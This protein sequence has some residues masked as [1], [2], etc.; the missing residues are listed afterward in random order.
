MPRRLHIHDL[1]PGLLT[2]NATQAHHARQVLRLV[3]GD[4]VELFDDAGRVARAEIVGGE[5]HEL[6]LR[7]DVVQDAPEFGF[8]WTVAAAVPKGERAD[9]MV[10]KLSE[11]GCH[12]FVPLIAERSVVTPKGTGKH[13][14]WV[15][16]ATESAKQCRRRGVMQVAPPTSLDDVLRMRAPGSTMWFFDTGPT[17]IPVRQLL[18]NPSPPPDLTL[19]VGPEG[20]WSTAEVDRMLDAHLTAVALTATILRIETAAVAAAAVIAAMWAGASPRT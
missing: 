15:R 19:L 3:D 1:Y 5:P 12:T 14:R 4:E 17:A 20:G 18:L 9:W 11:I 2:L 7:V 16:L 8:A 6:N 10:E 13:D